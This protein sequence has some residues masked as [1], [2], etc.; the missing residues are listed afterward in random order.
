MSSLGY[1]LFIVLRNS[2]LCWKFTSDMKRLLLIFP[3]L[4]IGAG[5][6][7]A[8]DIDMMDEVLIFDEAAGTA[9]VGVIVKNKNANQTTVNVSV[10]SN[11]GTASSSDMT[12]TTSSLSFAATTPDPDTMYINVTINNDM[13]VE[14]VEYFALRLSSA[15][16]GTIGDKETIVYIKDNDYTPPVARKNVELE[17]V[18]R[19]TMPGSGS[20]AEI[21]AYDS[22]TNRIFAVNS[23]KNEIEIINFANPAAPTQVSTID[24]STYGGGINSVAYHD[25]VVAVAVQ[26]SPKTDSGSIVF[27]DASGAYLNQ[28]K[29]GALPDMVT[30]TPDGKY[31]MSA[32]EGEPNDAYTIDPEGSITIV[33]MQNGVANATATHATFTTFNPLVNALKA[34]GVRI[35]GYNNP[36]L[37]QDVEPEYI[38]VNASSDTAIVSLQENNAVA[39][40]H[41]P[42]KTII[43]ILPLGYI[44]HSKA[45][46]GL[47]ATDRSPE[48][49]IANWPVRGLYLP[50][51][52]TSYIVNGTT[53][54]ILANEGDAREYDPFE[55]EER[56]K[57]IDLDP[58]AFP[59]GDLYQEDYAMGRLN[60]TTTLGDN[61]ND[62]K[63]ETLYSYGTR[64]IAIVN[65]SNGSLTWESGDQFEQIILADPK[66]GKLFNASNDDN[67]ARGRSDNK[68]P[69]PEAVTT[70]TIRDTVYAFVGLERIG[71]V[72]VYDVTNASAPVF[73]DYINTR[74]TAAFGGDNGP[75]CLVFLHEDANPHGKHYL[76]SANEVSGTVAVFE[77][78]VQPLGISAVDNNLMNLN[79]YP[80]P[81]Q[82][83][84]LF[85]STTVSGNM[86]DMNGRNVATFTKANSINT[87]NLAP[88][89]YF[90]NAEGFKVQKVIVQ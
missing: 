70:G 22:S 14:A 72:M 32:N 74:D 23:E 78:K 76:L 58:V 9:K 34:Q 77:V 89:T 30:F 81:V 66:V 19:Y 51:A 63:Y 24:M 49:L 67:D 16:N 20:S 43:S 42:S 53:Y 45:G 11:F 40:V 83:G 59:E 65:A 61:N 27:L 79:V 6:V 54:V 29:A 21:I 7:R 35:F 90:V 26:A 82:N 60:I 88:G 47:D 87:A 12:L 10:V 52:I 71:G 41:I 2:F 28:V 13:D 46:N 50:D 25:G 39:V 68:G 86:Y 36:T 62:G 80:N 57:S 64:G 37:A 55:E 56:I 3:L 4:L 15:V 18:G 31:V 75:E 8:Q 33:D 73:V 48:P 84:Q 85:F 17:F 69:E 5:A 1:G 38:A 44:D